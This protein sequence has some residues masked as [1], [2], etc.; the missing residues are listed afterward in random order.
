MKYQSNNSR[1]GFIKTRLLAVSKQTMIR[2]ALLCSLFLNACDEIN[3]AA[4]GGGETVAFP[5]AEGFGRLATGGRGGAVYYVTNLNNSGPGSL[6]DAVSQPNRTILFKVSGTIFLESN[7]FITNDNI[8]IAGQ[9]APGDG[10]CVAGR[11]TAIRA[12]NIII[13]HLRF[14]LG[15]LSE[16]N[17]DALY[18]SLPPAGTTPY[19]NIII[20]HCSLSWSV[21]EIGSFYALTDFTLQWCILSE[22]L[23][24]SIHEKGAHGY[25]GIWG[26]NRVSFHHNLL[27]HN[28]SRNPR[29]AGTLAATGPGEELV[30]FRNNVIYNWGHINSTYGGEGGHYNMVNNYYKY[31]PATPGSLTSSI[32]NKR[33]RILQYTSFA[34]SQGDTVW[35]GQFHI[36]GNYVDGFPDVTADN[37]TKGVQPD[38][39]SGA[40]GL[41]AAAKQINPFPFGQVTTQTAQQAYLAVLD[42]AGATLPKRD[43]IDRRIVRETRNRE[44]TYEGAA[45]ALI[46]TTGIHHPAGIID[47]QTDVGGW[48]TLLS[49]TP[50]TDSDNDGMPDWWEDE[51]GLNPADP[52]D[53]N[54]LTADGYTM[55]EKYIN[56]IGQ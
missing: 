8:T 22:S 18:S 19:N 56:S 43:T 10:I 27:A 42:S 24:S 46:G 16:T 29:F 31:G 14:R 2:N 44:A 21:D 38:S 51:E 50:E 32:S 5:G 28:T 9:T 52:D 49:D 20:D 17:L 33:N 54:L 35:G 55:L 30:D 40:S 53:R 13:R 3:L 48:P 7:L 36:D 23:Y 26:G 12:N 37:W 47:S 25:A 6:R 1:L 11:G 34:I 15:D 41:I 45:Y 39:Y 4:T